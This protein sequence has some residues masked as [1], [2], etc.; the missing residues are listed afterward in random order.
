MK[1]TAVALA[2]ILSAS[3]LLGGCGKK[4][5]VIIPMEELPSVDYSAY[6]TPAEIVTLDL[7]QEDPSNDVMRFEY[8][9]DG[10]IKRCCYQISGYDVIV[11]YNYDGDATLHAFLVTEGTETEV[12]TKVFRDV[13]SYDP[14]VGFSVHEGYYFKGFTF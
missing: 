11:S 5:K 1:K 8:Y 2:A 12:A 10:S 6:V 14:A 3:A 4:N 9:A 13:G 7:T